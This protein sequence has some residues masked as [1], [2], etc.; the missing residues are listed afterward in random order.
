MTSSIRGSVEGGDVFNASA[1][2]G[3]AEV[4]K[5]ISSIQMRKV[6]FQKLYEEMKERHIALID[7]YQDC[8]RTLEKSKEENQQM[9]DKF[10]NLL[11]KLQMENRKKDMKI[12]EM[13]TQVR[14]I[15]L[16]SS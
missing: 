5:E 11:D 14:H 7:T 10:K 2:G 13:K 1:T 4:A 15:R 9:Q 8:Q 12:E 16:S 6:Q 3:G